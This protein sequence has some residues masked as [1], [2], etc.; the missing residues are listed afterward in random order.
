MGII[1]FFLKVAI[2]EKF[3]MSAATKALSMA[4]AYAKPRFATFLKYGKT[5]LAPPTPG[6]LIQGVGQAAKLVSS[7]A[8]MQFRHLTVK[9]AWLN[10]LV[11]VEVACWFFVGECIGKGSLIAYQV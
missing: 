8:T 7:A 6:E 9:E 5:E 11:G 4:Q 10:T 3:K 1:E 2:F